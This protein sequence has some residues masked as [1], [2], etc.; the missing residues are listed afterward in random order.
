[1]S[2]FTD[3]SRTLVHDSTDAPAPVFDDTS[4]TLVHESLSRLIAS[5]RSFVA[6]GCCEAEERNHA[7]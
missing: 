1:M 7:D 2:D 6:C 5:R 4:R 3:E